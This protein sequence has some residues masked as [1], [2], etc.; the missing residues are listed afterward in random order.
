M[1]LFKEDA[2]YVYVDLKPKP[3]R[4]NRSSEVCP[5]PTAPRRANSLTPAEVFIVKPNYE[6]AKLTEPE[7]MSGINEESFVA[8][9]S[10][11]LAT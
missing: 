4:R 1:W 11:I 7:I 9:E 5:A 3:T 8:S 6:M 10:Q 2:H